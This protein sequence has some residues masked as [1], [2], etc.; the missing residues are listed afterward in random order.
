MSS[1]NSLAT[2]GW[3]VN[4]IFRPEAKIFLALLLLGTIYVGNAW[5]PSSYA[6]ALEF[7]QA[8]ETGL[9]L[10][11]ARNIRSDEWAVVTPLTQA[12][13]NNGMQRINATSYYGEDLRMMYSLPVRDWGMIFKPTQWSFLFIHPARAFSLHHFSVIFLFLYGYFLLFR[14]IGTGI[15]EGFLLACILFFTG[16]TQYWWTVLGPVL[17]FF[18]WVLLA[19]ETRPPIF[20]WLLLYYAGTCWILSFFYPPVIISLGFFGFFFLAAY[21]RDLL[22]SR[23]LLV[24]LTASAAAV[25]TACFYLRDYLAANWHTVYPG[26]RRSGGGTV[27]FD[28]WISQFLPTSQIDHHRS[29]IG[30]NICEIGVVGSLYLLLIICFLNYRNVF[31]PTEKRWECRPLIVLLAG[32]LFF[33]AWMFLPIPPAVGRFLLLDWV[34]PSRMVFAAGLMLLLF[35]FEMLRRCGLR[36]SSQRLA[37]FLLLIAGGTF[38]FKHLRSGLPIGKYWRDLVPLV[39]ILFLTFVFSPR[40]FDTRTCNRYFLIVAV[41]SGIF[42]FGRFNPLQSAWAIFEREPTPISRIL[43]EEARRNEGVVAKSG[44]PGAVLNGWGYRS[45]SHVLAAPNL[46]LWEGL[47][48]GMAEVERERIFNRYAHIAV[49]NE[50]S[51]R[52]MQADLICVPRERFISRTTAREATLGF[53]GDWPAE[54]RRKSDASTGETF[55]LFTPDSLPACIPPSTLVTGRITEKIKGSTL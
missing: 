18:P 37:I 55:R 7:F 12:T 50:A 47:F 13:I 24:L 8:K 45:V 33:Y 46:K 25:G 2:S 44:F 3:W 26:Q 4:L 21:R 32:L 1:E 49:G 20:R 36:W 17:A 23:S 10:G 29:L 38:Y 5:S 41:A 48:P 9:I 22:F 28:L 53:S 43:N 6:K 54:S 31:P 52:L 15:T 40:R 42:T 39:P 11:K 51:P 30:T 27:D 16:F 35:A 34:P 14:R 19:A